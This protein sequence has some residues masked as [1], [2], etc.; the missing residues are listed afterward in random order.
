[1]AYIDSKHLFKCET[2]RHCKGDI[3]CDTF[4]DAGE[5]YVPDMSKIP[6]A[7]V[8]EVKQGKWELDPM[9]MRQDGDSYDYCCS[10]CKGEAHTGEYGN[11]DVLADFCHHCG[12][13]MRNS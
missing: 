5:Q 2:C 7:D 1:M 3:K 13:D 12:A 9:L 8:K 6:T 10:I 11:N 4:C